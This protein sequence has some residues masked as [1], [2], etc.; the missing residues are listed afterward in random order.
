MPTESLTAATLRAV[1]VRVV[2]RVQGLGVRPV[3]ARLAARLRLAGVAANTADGL[4]LELEGRGDA[5][6]RFLA[7]FADALPAGA[8]IDR[9]D[10]EADK[11]RDRSGFQIA[12][13]SIAGDRSGAG[14]G[15]AAVPLD[16][17][18]C[19]TCLQEVYDDADR[20]R[21]YPFTS[22][23]L[24][25]PRYSIIEAM[26]YNR[27]ATTMQKF[28]L[29]PSCDREYRNSSDR[30]FHAQT[31]A[32]PKCDPQIWFVDEGKRTVGGDQAVNA[33]A[34]ALNAGRIV[35]LKGL[36]GYQ[37]LVDATSSDAVR[38]L[39]HKKN[40]NTKPLAVLVGSLDE[41]ERLA[42]LNDAERRL[43]RDPAGPIVVI[44]RRTDALLTA[45]IAPGFD[46]VGL[47]LP[48][49]PLHALLCA[50]AARPL[51]CTSGNR[52]G[53]PL[54]YDEQTAERE[55]ADIAD[56]WLHHDRAIA[57][58]IDDSV[59]RMVADSPCVLRLARGY[60]PYVLP[61]L[62]GLDAPIVALGG[63]QKA[64]VALWNGSQV[65]LGP[66]VG[67]LTGAAACERWVAQLE[68][69][70]ALYGTSP[71]AAEVVHDRHPDYFSTAWAQ[72][73]LRRHAVQHHHAHVAAVLLER[74]E[75]DRE[76]LGLAWDGTGYG[77]DG[78]V[79]GGEC[80]RATGRDYC[81]IARLRPFPLV[82][83]NQGLREP[84]RVAATLVHEALG[85][86]PTLKLRWPKVSTKQL[87]AVIDAAARPRLSA[88]TSSM[89]RLFDAVAALALGVTTADDDGRP[90]MLLE[91]AC[92][93]SAEGAY[94]FVHR[95]DDGDLDW[96]PVVAAVVDD[97]HR[98]ASPGAVAMRF[99]RAV[100]DLASSLGAA[101]ANLPL[102]TAG[103]VFQNAVLGELL[104]E[105]L[106]TRPGRWLHSQFV[107]PGDG[108][109][110]AGQLAVAAARLLQRAKG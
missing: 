45:D 36:G 76:V 58:P 109:L 59:V 80:L 52:E 11:P 14:P 62:P 19:E 17:V 100:A 15:A 2:G 38:R 33:A 5:I 12:A 48:T 98:G 73:F 87:C 65:V 28:A 84:W 41:A 1:R 44:R 56:V 4:T 42:F 110:A 68:S 64:S 7:E 81:R 101:H 83:G 34:A 74:G 55:L 8:V 53:E 86:G 6:E 77:D 66:H 13:H 16:R 29:C 94:A 60:A 46:S 93:R 20:R 107:P 70:T 30:R 43:L 24:C 57:R 23:T 18:V 89:G 10:V 92:D 40:R 49:T 22:C 39:R 90:A 69:F 27:P 97:L 25:G 21:H 9:L 51:V 63:E 26:P 79:W 32:C 85:P 54:V 108:G 102:V 35:A 75:L 82:G 104:T 106:A 72:R 47:L 31:N 95:V 61:S 105:R 91:A 50:R 96:R 67:D 37:L 88:A 78:T 3:A 99:H 103:G 71:A